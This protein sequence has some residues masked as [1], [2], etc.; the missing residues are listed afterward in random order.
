MNERRAP[1]EYPWEPMR[2]REVAQL[3]QR[4]PGRWWIA[5]GWSLDLYLGHPT[6]EH[7]DVDVL[8]LYD[9]LPTIHAAL[10]GWEFAGWHFSNEQPELRPW[11]PGETLPPQT[12][13]VWGR[14]A[15]TEAWR[16]RLMTMHTEGDRWILPRDASFTGE[17]A[18]LSDVRNGIPIVAPELQLLSKARVPHRPKDDADLRRMIPHLW[19]RRQAWLREAIMR[20]YPTSPALR[21]LGGP[22]PVSGQ[23]GT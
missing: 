23:V 14:P 6:R 16:F 22:A 1:D 3:F 8:V 18:M 21:L 19:H 15:G 2:P 11:L 4:C 5:G 7:E 17:L 13:D 10:P 12:R 20:L 9:D